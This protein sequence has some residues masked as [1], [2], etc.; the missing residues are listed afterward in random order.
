MFSQFGVMSFRPRQ[1]F[2]GS[3][4]QLIAPVFLGKARVL[5]HNLTW[6]TMTL[7]LNRVLANKYPTTAPEWSRS[8]WKPRPKW[9]AEGPKDRLRFLPEMG[10]MGVRSPFQ[11]RRAA[12]P[13][14]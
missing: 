2:L 5:S 9:L 3:L 4:S 10:P 8:L 7:L 13:N 14:D 1:A 6:A 12:D 11:G